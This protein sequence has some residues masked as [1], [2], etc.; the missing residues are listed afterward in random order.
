[1]LSLE[2]NSFR[3]SIAVQFRVVHALLM[4]ELITRFGRENLG[5]L[6]LVAEP[7]LFTL[8]VVVLWTVGGLHAGGQVSIVAFSVTGYSTILLW[9]N[10]T[11]RCATAIEENKHLLFHRNVRV[12]DAFAARIVLETTGATCSFIILSMTFMYAGGMA[13]PVDLLKVVTGWVLI[14]WF[15]AGLGMMVGSLAAFSEVVHRIWHPV[16]YFMLPFSGA[17]LMV[18]WTPPAVRQ[19][20]LLFPMAEG[21]EMLREGWFGNAVIA[22]YDVPYTVSCCLVLSLIALGLQSV[23][24]RILE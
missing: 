17:L 7:M 23:A 13:P 24:S 20:I 16:S 11:N 10:T 21:T 19:V 4:R 15:A 1:M 8:G 2:H 6:W 14:A 5:V 18:E 9:R 22:H 3:N 12:I